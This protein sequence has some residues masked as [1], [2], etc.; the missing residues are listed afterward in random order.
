MNIIRACA[1][2]AAIGAHSLSGGLNPVCGD[3]ISFQVFE[4]E[5]AAP[6]AGLDLT[7][8]LVQ[9]GS[10]LHLIFANQ[11]AIPAVVTALY[12]EQTPTSAALLANPLLVQPFQTGIVFTLGASPANPPGSIADFGGHWQGTW[13]SASAAAPSAANGIGPG[14]SLTLSFDLLG[15]ES[16]VHSAIAAG[17][18]RIVQHV[19]ALAGGQSLWTTTV[20]APGAL[21]VLL[22]AAAAGRRRRR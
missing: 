13:A 14:E 21:P 9:Q 20:P 1:V 6:T 4:N 19:Q 7:V 10:A 18:I 22:A 8:E 15:A 16:Q 2:F 3:V 12:V 17:E 11:S 5:G